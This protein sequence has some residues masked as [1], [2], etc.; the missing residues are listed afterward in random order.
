MGMRAAA[1]AIALLP[2]FASAEAVNLFCSGSDPDW[3]LLYNETS[4]Q[5]DFAGRI[6]DMQVPQ[7]STVEGGDWPRAA[8]LIAPRD[9][10][11]VIIHKRECGDGD[12]EMQVLTQRG[13]TPLLLSGCCISHD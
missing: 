3:S 12:H 10:A 7:N 2:T 11:V 9:S 4:A 5:F 1:A 6:S 8:T 13:E